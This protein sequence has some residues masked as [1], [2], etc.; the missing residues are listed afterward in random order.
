MFQRNKSFSVLYRLQRTL[1][2]IFY[3]VSVLSLFWVI[4]YI[5]DVV[6]GLKGVTI[7][8]LSIVYL[9]L[10]VLAYSFIHVVSYIPSNLAGAFDPIQDA[11]ADGSLQSVRD[12]ARELSVFMV[13]FFN[14]AFFDIEFAFVKIRGDSSSW[15]AGEDTVDIGLNIGEL[16]RRYETVVETVYLGKVTSTGQGTGHLY[17]TPMIFGGEKLG[18]FA[19][20]TKNRL[21]RIFRRLLTEF[22]NHFVD[23][24]VVHI[25]A[26]ASGK[27]A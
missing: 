4:L 21:W 2:A 17:L 10:A 23:D 15:P 16:D 19:V 27:L 5:L 24:Q 3:L 20:I 26:G 8:L 14:F 22:E 11:I 25:L 12:F 18:Y 1:L 9:V 6:L 13:T 7:I